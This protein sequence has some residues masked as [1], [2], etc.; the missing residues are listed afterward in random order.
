MIDAGRQHTLPY[1]PATARPWRVALIAALAFLAGGG[2][3]A[4]A[5]KIG[6]SLPMSGN[7]ALLGRQFQDG[8]RLALEA[9]A[10]GGAVELVVVDDGCDADIAELAA[11]DLRNADVRLVTG[12]LCDA[13]AFAAAEAFQNRSVPVIIAGARSERLMKDRARHDWQVWRM[14]PADAD[15]ARAAAQGLSRR[16]TGR[17][18]ALVD[19]GTVYGRTLADEFRAIMEAA[20]LPPQFADTYRPAQSSQVPMLRR[21]QRAGVTAAF[22]AGAPED[23]AVIAGGA[24]EVGLEIELAGGPSLD[25]LPWIE[26]R[27]MVPDGALA[28]IEPDPSSLPAAKDLTLTLEANG[29]EPEPYVYLGYAALQVALA[30]RRD[31]PAETARA[32]SAT[33]FGTVLG[34]VDFDETGI[35]RINPYRLYVWQGDSFRPIE[36]DGE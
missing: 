8:A 6:L 28:V 24:V 26:Q 19:D 3:P 21:L 30:A 13:A 17:P 18:W 22:V 12:L 1:P 33:V 20:G 14:A 15:A 16:W 32:L 2:A 11:A 31:D 5:Y 10:P 36:G 7:A 35:N 23:F 4:A 29:I 25:L 9:L 27:A 34:H